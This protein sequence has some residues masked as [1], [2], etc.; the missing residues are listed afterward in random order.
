MGATFVSYATAD[1]REAIA[2]CDA[3]EARGVACWMAG[4]DVRPGANYQEAIV[5]AIRTAR[6]LVLVFSDHANR[7]DE[8]KKELSL[9]SRFRVPVIAAR[10]ADVDP[11]DAFVYELSTRQ[12]IDIFTDRTRALDAVARSVAELGGV[13]GDGVRTDAIPPPRPVARRRRWWM[14]GVLAA[15][16]AIGGG[17]WWF[18]AHRDP[19]VGPGRAG[20][21]QVRLTGFERLTPDIPAGTDVALRDE[22]TAALADEGIVKV[23]NAAAPPPGTGAAFAVG[24][25]VRRDGAQVRIV[26]QLVNER[27]GATLWSQSLAYDTAQLSRVPR[28]VAANAGSVLRCGLFGAST[29]PHA[30]PDGA[31]ADYLTECFHHYA[32]DP[33]LAKGLDAARKVV[34]A[35][36]DF[37]WG[38]SGVAISAVM[39]AQRLPLGEATPMY[40]E[41]L[42]A[43]DRAIVLDPTNSEAFAWKS[44]AIDPAALAPREAL[45]RQAL[46]VRALSC[47][48]EHNIYGS[49]LDEVGRNAAAVGEY[50]RAVDT[51]ALEYESQEALAI[52]LTNTGDERSAK[53]HLDAAVDLTGDPGQRAIVALIL[54]PTTHDYEGAITDLDAPTMPYAKNILSAWRVA[55]KALAAGATGDRPAAVSALVALPD[56]GQETIITVG[57]L[58]ALG[59]N[60]EATALVERRAAAREPGARAFLFMPSMAGARAEPGFASVADR[61]GLMR[62]WRATRTRPDICGRATSPPFCRSI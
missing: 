1:R 7:S 45:I 30:L 43:V 39:T 34:G 5:S 56:E 51:L 26:L 32:L 11:S 27:S 13:E 24:G 4:R 48:C 53:E 18:A 60:R 15:L 38:W 12:W 33:Q 21:L 31:M 44:M 8:I 57:L 16:I 49:F 20:L 22:L 23:S 62:Y 14:A 37:S 36:P 59:A 17:G 61:L 10:I 50:R 19:A 41:A 47:G 54:A 29:Y 28:L 40:R 35:V 42:A 25:T 52:S 6:A 3:L 55:L 9:A 2:I 46:K 58:G